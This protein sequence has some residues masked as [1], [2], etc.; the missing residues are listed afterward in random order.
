MP[1]SQTKHIRS[2]MAQLMNDPD[3]DYVPD[4]L[5]KLVEETCLMLDHWEWLYD[6]GHSVWEIA[7]EF[8]DH[9]R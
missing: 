6:E 9:V 2:C 7:L 8:F 5:T 4:T 1:Y 3:P